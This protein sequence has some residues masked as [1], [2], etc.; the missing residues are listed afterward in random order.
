MFQCGSP[1]CFHGPLTKQQQARMQ[2]QDKRHFKGV[3]KQVSA[4]TAYILLVPPTQ[5]VCCTEDN[6]LCE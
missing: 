4:I 1:P 3:R 2:R 5:A 6:L